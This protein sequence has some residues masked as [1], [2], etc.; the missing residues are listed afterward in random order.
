MAD[1]AQL[2]QDIDNQRLKYLGLRQKLTTTLAAF[3]AP[4]DAQDHLISYAE[5]FGPEHAI[6]KLGAEPALFRVDV[7]PAVRNELAPLVVSL[8]DTG[9]SLDRLVR[10][11]EDILAKDDPKRKRVYMFFGRECTLDMVKGQ[12]NYLDAPGKPEPLN[13]QVVHTK[14]QPAPG[15]GL[16]SEPKEDQT[17]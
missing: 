9:Y 4:P 5:E 16:P 17:R 1:V 15:K 6:K 8:V 7:P 13:L 14:D 10:A 3:K 12:I 11:R 2:Q